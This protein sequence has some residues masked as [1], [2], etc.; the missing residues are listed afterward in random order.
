MNAI[1][2]VNRVYGFG[3]GTDMPWPKSS[4][5]LRRFKELTTGCT[6][7][8]GSGTWNSNMPK[9]L[10]NRRNIVLS[11]SL[12][13]SRCEVFRNVT[14]LLMNINADEKIWVIGGAKILW[15]LRY[16][17]HKVFL[18]RF[19]DTTRSE[20]TL[21]TDQYLQDFKLVKCDKFDDHTFEV[22]EKCML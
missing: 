11:K 16:N 8:M 22:W 21:D 17:I 7:V 3:T 9:P 14:D 10:P 5:D 18:T 15:M 20:V 6:I 13:D 12:E 2:A 1:F 4:A 19:D